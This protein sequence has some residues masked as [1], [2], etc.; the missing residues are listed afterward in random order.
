MLADAE[1]RNRNL[2][3]NGVQA[4]YRAASYDLRIGML[5]DSSGHIL[6]SYTV[7]PQGIVE[8]ISEETVRVPRNVSGFA[9]VKTG[10]CQ[11]GML[12]LSIGIIDPGFEGKISSFLVNFSKR[13]RLLQK[14][15]VFLR[16]VFHELTGDPEA[17][18]P[19]PLDN[20]TLKMQRRK[21]AVERFDSTFL[22][23]DQ[24]ASKS[25]EQVFSKYKNRMLGYVSAAALGLAI[26][27]F[28][29]NFGTIWLKWP[30]GPVSLVSEKPADM[31]E[32]R[33]LLR[34][35]ADLRNRIDTLE[36]QL[37]GKPTVSSVTGK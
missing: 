27:T 5:I 9:M 20:E 37:A 26:L 24:L 32:V 14:G 31:V 35:N 4:N 36:H 1:I 15:E 19:R 30:D 25:A 8:V 2:I 16:T 12:A 10:L 3:Q 22:S 23:I 13:E 11:E 33:Q 17:E 34:E 21:A 18:M 29:V 7:P 6:D 28:L